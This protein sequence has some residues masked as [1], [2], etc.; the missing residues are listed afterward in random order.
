MPDRLSTGRLV[1]V[2]CPPIIGISNFRDLGGLQAGSGV[3][4][5]GLLMRCAAPLVLEDDDRERLG[6][7]GLQTA[8]D[9][10][11][12][13]ER[14]NDP[15]EEFAPV[16]HSVPLFSGAVDLQTAR[17]LDAL[18]VDIIEAC[19]PRFVDAARI[20]CAPE[21]LPAVIFCSAGK[22]RTGILTALILSAVGVS[23]DDVARDFALSEQGISGEFRAELEARALLAGVTE[24]ALAVSMGAPADLMTGLLAELAAAH[25]GA[26]A[27]LLRNGLSEAGLAQL[28]R[29]LVG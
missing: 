16:V 9:L 4:K 7:L 2:W 29:T 14:K 3:I 21:A 18:Y 20:L 8:L 28:R 24:Q 11:E 13:I 25:G 19:G 23:D 15:V 22:D 6:A 1:E 27:Y 17:G 5:P 26:A 12:P 10:R